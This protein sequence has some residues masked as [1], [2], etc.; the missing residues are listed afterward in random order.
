M[1]APS[2]VNCVESMARR[3]SL[4]IAANEAAMRVAADGTPDTQ[5]LDDDG[6]ESQ[7]PD[8]S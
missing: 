2:S 1:V 6:E 7:V 8:I 3:N 5:V 4:I